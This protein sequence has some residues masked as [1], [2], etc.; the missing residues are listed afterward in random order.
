MHAELHTST[1]DQAP[2]ASCEPAATSA[3]ALVVLGREL[4]H[5]GYEFVAVSHA[6]H[7]RALRQR[8]AHAVDLRDVFGWNR[9]FDADLLPAPVLELVRAAGCCRVDGRRLRSTVRFSTIDGQLFAHPAFSADHDDA[10]GLGPD[11]YRFAAALLRH[12]P[13]SHRIVDVGCG[14][15]VGGILIASRAR[16][17]VLAD[18]DERALFFARVNATL[19]GISPD[20]VR[21]DVLDGVHGELDLV[22]ANAPH[23]HDAPSE[24]LA[25]RI[26][27][28]ALQ[29]LG[30]GGAL[31]L[32]TGTAIVDGCDTF[33]RAVVPLLDRG[34]A[35][36]VYEE[37]D[38]D[39]GGEELDEP[40][41]LDVE[42]VAA[43]LLRVT[44]D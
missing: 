43:V 2:V 34:D 1:F 19:A 16:Q 32:Y 4:V 3:E 42:R 12:A 8:C 27:H 21:S 10:I 39:L 31:I 29:R 11:S 41:Y 23:S 14:V 13:H 17:L 24:G 35:S 38:P 22:V 33:L 6:T 25:V 5:E 28:D 37:I 30:A 40:D 20:I 7:L 9:P 15:G 36:I 18:V 44:L 26:T